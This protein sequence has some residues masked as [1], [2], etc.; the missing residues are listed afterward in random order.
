MN[1][2]HPPIIRVAKQDD[3]NAFRRLWDI[4]FGD[5][6]AFCDWFFENRFIAEYSVVLESGGEICSCMQAFPYTVLIRGKEVPG[7]MLCGVSTDPYQRKNL[8]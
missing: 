1:D 7:A 2:N 4:C 8:K 3:R 5:S 6:N